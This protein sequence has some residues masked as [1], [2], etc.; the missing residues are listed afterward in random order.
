MRLSRT[1]PLPRAWST[2]AGLRSLRIRLGNLG[3]LGAAALLLA[4]ALLLVITPYLRM[5]AEAAREHMLAAERTERE[6]RIGAA[7]RARRVAARDGVVGAPDL[8]TA[9][10]RDARVARLLARASREGLQVGGLRQAALELD[11]ADR[12]SGVAPSQWH[13]VELPVRGSYAQIRSFMAAA[14]AADSAL[15]LDAVLLQR[16]AGGAPEA[17]RADTRW[18]FWQQVGTSGD[19]GA[20]R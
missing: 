6:M 2:G 3:M 1:S 7:D 11:I 19:P 8:P 17:V 9:R 14:L 20:S 13:T 15:A 18:S 12:R 5:Q 16:D 4:L 10:E